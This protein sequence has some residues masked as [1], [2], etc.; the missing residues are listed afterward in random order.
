R[1]CDHGRGAL[2]GRAPAP[3]TLKPN[4]VM[5]RSNG[6][7]IASPPKLMN[8]HPPRPP[9]TTLEAV[10]RASSLQ[11]VRSAAAARG[12]IGR[13]AVT[14]AN[15]AGWPPATPQP[16]ADTGGSGP[17]CT[18]AVYPRAIMQPA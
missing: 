15:S 4:G 17:T 6:L 1:G 18:C 8:G 16:R 10:A 2:S 14:D 12:P 13:A 7:S 3:P 5:H 11:P 9:E